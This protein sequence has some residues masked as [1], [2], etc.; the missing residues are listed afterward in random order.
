[1]G[2]SNNCQYFIRDVLDANGLLTE[3]YLVFIKQETESLLS[4][5]TGFRQLANNVTDIEAA[6]NTVMEGSGLAKLQFSN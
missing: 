3:Q 1:M 2:S 5:N 6:A 4:N